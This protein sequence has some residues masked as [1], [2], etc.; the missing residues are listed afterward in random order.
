MELTR[1]NGK[2]VMELSDPIT[3]VQSSKLWEEEMR[4]TKNNR[5][6]MQCEKCNSLLHVEQPSTV[7]HV[8]LTNH[9]D[10]P[11][12]FFIM[13]QQQLYANMNHQPRY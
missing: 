6:K 4:N 5:T 10:I 2:K 8:I 13:F 9:N 12:D 1:R 7:P 3:R 11:N